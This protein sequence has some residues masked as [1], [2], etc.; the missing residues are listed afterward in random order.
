MPPF[1][2]ISRINTSLLI[3]RSLICGA[4]KVWMKTKKKEFVET[5]EIVNENLGSYNN[6]D[7]FQVPQ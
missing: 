2:Q 3:G 1:W 5:S 6:T 4:E 7:C